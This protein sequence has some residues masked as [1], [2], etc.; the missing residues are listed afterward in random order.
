MKIMKYISIL[1]LSM[2][3]T[4]TLDETLNNSDI[5]EIAQKALLHRE[6]CNG[7]ACK[8]EYDKKMEEAA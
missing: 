8:G 4:N 7:L 1:F 6:K 5:I 2:V 3:F